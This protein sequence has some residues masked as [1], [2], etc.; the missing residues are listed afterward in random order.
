[1]LNSLMHLKLLQK[2]Q[3]KR[4]HTTGNLIGNKHFK[5]KDKVILSFFKEI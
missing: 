5:D 1:M 2:Q 4:T 3:L